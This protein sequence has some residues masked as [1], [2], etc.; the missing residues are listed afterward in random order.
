M[1]I[2]AWFFFTSNK[3]HLSLSQVEKYEELTQSGKLENY[4]KRKQKKNLGKEKR[5]TLK[6]KS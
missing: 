6:S 2:S 4:M 1:D 3:D 5:N